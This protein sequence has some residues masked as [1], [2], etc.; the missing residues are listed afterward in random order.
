MDCDIESEISVCSRDSLTSPKREEG[1]VN[2]LG[3][4]QLSAERHEGRNASGRKSAEVLNAKRLSIAEKRSRCY[5]NG[6]VKK[7][8]KDCIDLKGNL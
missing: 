6:R 7:N 3:R 1:E 5:S 4:W 8:E 2:C